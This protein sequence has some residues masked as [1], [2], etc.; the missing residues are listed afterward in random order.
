VP[1]N[2]VEEGYILCKNME[3][4]IDMFSEELYELDFAEY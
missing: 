3:K 4:V 2:R 1:S